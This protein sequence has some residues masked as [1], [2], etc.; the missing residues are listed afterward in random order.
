MTS[1]APA[2]VEEVVLK[3]YGVQRESCW[4]QGC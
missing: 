2:F 4:S 3:D 1:V